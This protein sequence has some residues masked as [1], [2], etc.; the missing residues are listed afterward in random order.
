MRGDLLKQFT[1]AKQQQQQQNYRSIPVILSVS[2]QF[3]CNSPNE[4]N[5]IELGRESK[6]AEQR[7]KEEKAK[8]NRW[9]Q[10]TKTQTESESDGR[11]KIN[12]IAYTHRPISIKFF[13]KK[14][15]RK[16]PF[17]L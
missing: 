8:K 6:E 14:K 17:L 11:R 15:T 12:Q 10:K 5:W 13:K 3:Y 7:P 1:T 9:E 2:K 4:R 16:K